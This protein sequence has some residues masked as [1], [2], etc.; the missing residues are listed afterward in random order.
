MGDELVEGRP[1]SVTDGE[2]VGGNDE[3]TTVPPRYTAVEGEGVDRQGY[4]EEK[5]GRVTQHTAHQFTTDLLKMSSH[6]SVTISPT[7]VLSTAE[8]SREAA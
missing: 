5:P 7:R 4:K 8:R 1:R 3:L 6:S 2:S